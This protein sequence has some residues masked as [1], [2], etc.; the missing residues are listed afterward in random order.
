MFQVKGNQSHHMFEIDLLVNPLS[1]NAQKLMPVLKFLNNLIP[2]KISVFLHPYLS[3]ESM[4]LKQYYRAALPQLTFS[5]DG[6]LE[7]VAASKAHFQDL[8]EHKLLTLNPETPAA[9]LIEPLVAK[10]DLDNIRLV[11][12]EEEDLMVEYGLESILLTGSCLDTT[13]RTRRDVYPRGVQIK[14]GS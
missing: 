4:P 8:P 9:W 10:L 13:A 3:Q 1:G 12:L 14:L 2:A 7:A 11:D 6:T 5:Q